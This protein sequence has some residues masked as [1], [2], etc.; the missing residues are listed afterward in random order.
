MRLTPVAI[1]VPLISM[2]VLPWAGCA[3]FDPRSTDEIL[4]DPSSEWSPPE[5]LTVIMAAAA[6]NLLDNRTNIKAIVTPYYPSVIRALGRK[7]QRE[8]RWG[9]DEYHR[10]VDKLVHES[11]GMY[12]DW[13]QSNE[14]LYGAEL[15]PVT[16]PTD[17]DSLLVLLT[18]TNK[19]WPCGKQLA[20]SVPTPEGGRREIFIPL[21][22]PDCIPPDIT[23]LEERIFLVN[24]RKD[25]LRPKFVW[26]R[27]MSYLTNI[28]ETLYAKFRFVGGDVHFLEGSSRFFLAIAGFER[29]IELE[30]QVSGMR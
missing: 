14:P 7:A 28:D 3:T 16:K 12:I 24:E 13:E 8:Y 1:L 5:Q 20:I 23:G 22:E 15:K 25:T 11:S 26:G 29:K 2:F 10:Y 6:D 27:R 9:E 18:I 19:G 4:L 17:F 21:E 30:F